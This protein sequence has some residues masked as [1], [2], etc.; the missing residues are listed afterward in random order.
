MDCPRQVGGPTFGPASGRPSVTQVHAPKCGDMRDRSKCSS[1]F[2]V[3]IR[4]SKVY[5]FTRSKGNGSLL[6]NVNV[7]EGLQLALFRKE[8]RHKWMRWRVQTAKDSTLN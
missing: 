2:V 5:I 7:F 3:A 6:K 4:N 8:Y 1:L